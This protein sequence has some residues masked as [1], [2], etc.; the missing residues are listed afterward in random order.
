MLVPDV[1]KETEAAT[2][3]R[4]VAG[5]VVAMPEGWAANADVN[6]L[7]QRDGFDALEALLS[8]ASEPVKPV[9]RMTVSIS[10]RRRATSDRP[11][12]WI[13]LPV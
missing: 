6:D 2:I 8:G 13:W 5:V 12:S 3:A 10:P 1:G 11:R 4:E 9:R 7:A